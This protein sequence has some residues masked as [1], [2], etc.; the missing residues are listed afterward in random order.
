MLVVCRAPNFSTRPQ[1]R[2][3]SSGVPASADQA[4]QRSGRGDAP[5]RPGPDRGRHTAGRPLPSAE[6]FDPA[7]R[8]LLDSASS[9]DRGRRSPNRAAARRGDAPGRA[10]PDRRRRK[11]RRL[12]RIERGTIQP[13]HEHV[14]RSSRAPASRSSR[15]QPQRRSPRAGPDRRRGHARA[16]VQPHHGHLHKAH[17]HGPYVAREGAVAATLPYGQVLIAGGTTGSGTWATH[18]PRTPKARNSSTPPRTPSR[19]SRAPPVAHR[20]TSGAVAATLPDGQVLIAGGLT[21]PLPLERRTV[22][23]RHGHLHEAHR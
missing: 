19:S 14:H 8:P 1:T 18:F 3:R 20:S 10:G 4:A 9:R 11:P 13:R 22:Q 16:T 23:P 5:G 17:Q 6:L 2:S 15:R 21:G 7:R 12:P